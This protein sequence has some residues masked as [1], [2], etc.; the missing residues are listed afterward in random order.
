MDKDLKVEDLLA[1][2]GETVDAKIQGAIADLKAVQPPPAPAK[3]EP[4]VEVKTPHDALFK[5]VVGV[6]PRLHT[7]WMQ[8]R[9]N[10][11]HVGDV[12]KALFT[13]PHER[14]RD[15]AIILEHCKTTMVVGTD[16][17]GGYAVPPGFVNEILYLADYYSDIFNIVD[18]IPMG[19]NTKIP[20]GTNACVAYWP[21]E[22]VA[23]TLS[24]PTLSP[25]SLSANPGGV[26]VRANR[27]IEAFSGPD[28]V[29]WVLKCMAETV[30][31]DAESK[32]V[33]GTGSSQPKGFTHAD[34][35]SVSAVSLDG[36]TLAYLDL[37]DLAYAVNRKYRGPGCCWLFNDTA[38]ELID[39][40]RDSDG[41]PIMIRWWGGQGSVGDKDFG[42]PQGRL[43]G[44]PFFI[45]PSISST[46]GSSGAYTTRIYFGNFKHGYKVGRTSIARM[47][48]SYEAGSDTFL[49]DDLILKYLAWWDGRLAVEAAIAYLTGVK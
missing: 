4:T 3:P 35:S 32:I 24:N 18:T 14:T 43:M 23:L 10:F 44:Y 47:E 8:D 19:L 6:M 7:Q 37:V 27:S 40:L 41:R 49:A 16:N 42:A 28:L 26:A 34:Y 45:V 21:G 29:G 39:G 13:Q 5:G 15:Q 12:L 2:I 38:A 46:Y 9:E 11:K 48:K 22:A 1:K 30:A 20:L 17:V 31:T 25:L 33:N 36:S